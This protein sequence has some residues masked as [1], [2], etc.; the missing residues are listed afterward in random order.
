MSGNRDGQDHTGS[1]Q[2]SAFVRA[3]P[4]EHQFE[5]RS[6]VNAEMAHS[7]ALAAGWPAEHLT[8]DAQASFR[9]GGGVGLIV[10]RLRKLAGTKP[11]KQADRAGEPKMGCPRGCGKPHLSHQGCECV[12]CGQPTAR[13]V[14]DGVGACHGPCHTGRPAQRA[15]QL[16]TPESRA[17]PATEPDLT[18]TQVAERVALLLPLATSACT[19]DEAEQ[20]MRD[21]IERQYA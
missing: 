2:W 14:I 6:S 4:E 1:A 5:L 17:R 12:Y 11:A 3:Q 13:M 16:E 9:R 21:L 20:Q 18:P 19:P 10:S 15:P 8:Q 7:D